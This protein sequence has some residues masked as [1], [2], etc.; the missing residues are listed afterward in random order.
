MSLQLPI[1]FGSILKLMSGVDI[2]INN[3]SQYTGISSYP[4]DLLSF[5][6]KQEYIELI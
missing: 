2:D 4:T 1:N 3:T 6:L 5:G